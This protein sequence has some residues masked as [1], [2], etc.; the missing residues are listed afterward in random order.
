MPRTRS[1]GRGHGR[2]RAGGRGGTL[3]SPVGANSPNSSLPSSVSSSGIQ[4]QGQTRVP[5]PIFDPDNYHVWCFTM[6]SF[7]TAEGCFGA[8]DKVSNDWENLDSSQKMILKHRAFNLLRYSMGNS[9]VYVCAEF[10]VHQAHKLWQHIRSMFVKDDLSTRLSLQ[11]RFQEVFWDTSRHHVDS[12]LQELYMIRMEH[13]NAGFDLDDET[14]FTKLLLCLPSQFD[15]EKAQMKE[16][17]EMNLGRA[18]KILK[19]RED[20]LENRRRASSST[21]LVEGTAFTAVATTDPRAGVKKCTFCRKMGHTYHQCFRL[22]R[23]QEE[24]KS[25]RGRGG[26]ISNNGLRNVTASSSSAPVSTQG[27][28]NSNSHSSSSSGSIHIAYSDQAS[29]SSS[30]VSSDFV[31]GSSG[32]EEL[33]YVNAD[34][35]Q[36][37]MGFFFMMADGSVSNWVLDTGATHHLC[38]N[39]AYLHNVTPASVN[40]TT[41]KSNALLHITISGHLALKGCDSSFKGVDLCNV[42]YSPDASTNIIAIHPFVKKGCTVVIE[43]QRL[44]VLFNGQVILYGKDNGKGLY[45]LQSHCIEQTEQATCLSLHSIPKS[46]ALRLL[47]NRFGHLNPEAIKQMCKEGLVQGLPS[48]LKFD[49]TEF[50]CT[51]CLMGKSTRLPYNNSEKPPVVVGDNLN[52]GDEIVSDT[53]GPIEPISR[54]GNRFVIEFIDVA[55]RFAFMFPITSLELVASKYVLLRNLIQT[56]KGICIKILHTDGHGSYQSNEILSIL[57]KDGT[58]H[59]MRSP[60]SPEQNSIA[61]RRIRTVVEMARTIL[62]QSCVPSMCWE[63][64]ILHANYIRNRVYTRSIAGKTPYEAF[65]GRKPNMEYIRPFGCLVYVLIHKE[66]R[67]GKFDATS[68]PGVLL[69]ISDH[70]SGYKVLMIGDRTVKVARDVRFYEEIFPFR[71]SPMTDLRWMNPQD[72]PEISSNELGVFKDPFVL[73]S[74]GSKRQRDTE[75]SSLYEQT[76]AKQIDMLA[77]QSS[78]QLLISGATEGVCIANTLPEPYKSPIGVLFEEGAILSIHEY[79]IRE[80]ISGPNQEKWLTALKTEFGAIMATDTFVKMTPEATKLLNEGKIRVHKTRA[81]L[82]TKLN[83]SGQIARYKARLV[84]LGYSMAKGVDYDETFSPC[85][86]LNTVRLVIALAASMKWTVTHSDVPNAY[87]NGA[88]PRLIVVKLPEIW[89]EV[90]GDDLG[91]NGDPVI[92]ANSLYGAPDAGRNWNKTFASTFTQEGYSS[93]IKEPC[94]FFK[95][96]FPNIAIFTIWVDDCFITGGDLIEIERMQSVLTQKFKIKKLGIVSFALGIAFSWGSDHVKMTQTAYIERIAA[97]YGLSEAK[98]ISLPLQKGFKPLHSHSPSLPNEIEDMKRIPYRSAIGSL[99]YV[100]LGTRPDIAYAVC[101]LARFSHNPGRIHWS[102]VKN[103]IKYLMHTKDVGLTYK[104]QSTPKDATGV[105][106]SGYADSSFNDH[107]DGRST[108][109]HAC[110]MNGY[111]ISWRS[112]VSSNI[113]QSVFESEWVSLNSLTREVIWTRDVI[114]Q[115]LQCSMHA[116]TIKVDNKA[117]VERTDQK[118]CE[119]NRHF[120][121][122]YFFVLQALQDGHISVT[123]VS[124]EE[125]VADI[126]TKALGNPIYQGHVRALCLA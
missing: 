72:C 90:M 35:V 111:L 99:L 93:S 9:Y 22:K 44:K 88:C 17:N 12:F 13:K 69:G 47:H 62:L 70:H 4:P 114:T 100:A 1:R 83:E 23:R 77:K 108:L 121:P 66:L 36:T 7:L 79:N 51:H 46:D 118:I 96:A 28:T 82:T 85:A 29:S 6:K 81:I 120:R 37:E 94:V 76:P 25:Q 109:G 87:L 78:G 71:R 19:E 24:R 39:I 11:K 126:L 38:N 123:K 86:R 106:I 59:K 5:V 119:S 45:V 95:G 18:R 89:N 63:D 98:P 30:N 31:F 21:P 64:A 14:V 75:L 15:I 49:S 61:E 55:S 20:T 3:P 50:S 124:S 56:Q 104:F 92:M 113:P 40:I 58:F 91:K 110:F 2:G 84:V 105:V 112:K 10:Q 107:E 117:C 32:K 8:I 97:Q 54:N 68:L 48:D 122:R 115:V 101:A 60:Y 53:F 125:N 42:L 43:E 116:S 41:G 26:A 103:V 102:M 33:V 57:A 16:W 73:P 52:I 74:A 65:W 34:E 67:D 80:A 27:N